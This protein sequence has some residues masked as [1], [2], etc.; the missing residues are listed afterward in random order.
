MEAKYYA[1]GEDAFAM[2]RDLSNVA[3]M[4]AREKR[5]EPSRHQKSLPGSRRNKTS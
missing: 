4:I 2:K 5:D 1:D 3:E